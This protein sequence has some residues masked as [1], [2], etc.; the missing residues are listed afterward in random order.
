VTLYTSRRSEFM[1]TRILVPLDGSPY[2][3]EALPFAA[4]IA[5]ASGAELLLAAVFDTGVLYPAYFGPVPLPQSEID[6]QFAAFDAYLRQLTSDPEVQGIAV[7]TTVLSGPTALTLLAAIEDER[8]DL[9]ALNS[10][11]RHG[12]ARW[13]LG[14]VAE[15]LTRSS[16]APLLILRQPTG[17]AED[18]R[19]ETPWHAVIGL[20]GS[21][22]AEEAL[23]PT[24]QIAQALSGTQSAQIQLA[25]VV[26]P[27]S[28]LDDLGRALTDT[29]QARAAHAELAREARRELETVSD[30]LRAESSA[31]QIT[32]TVVEYP[33]PAAAL[34]NLAERP[35]DKAALEGHP[36]VLLGVATHGRTGLARWTV[37]SVAA[38][39]LEGSHTP[40]VVVRPAAIAAQQRAN[41]E[42]AD[43]TPQ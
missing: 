24:I 19:F 35:Q 9:V 16:P 37:G 21:A 43:A 34:I 20:D 39:I 33:D 27:V 7:R 41:R 22:Y 2:A 25:R 14:S 8:I 40:L 6:E 13:W 17:A 10:H 4:R 18:A 26:H 12:V 42:Q 30:R 38:R 15:Y 3:A 1:F 5:R 32:R 31:A 29:V 23:A 36:H 11:G 28:D